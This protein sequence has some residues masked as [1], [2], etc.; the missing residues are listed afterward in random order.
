MYSTLLPVFCLIHRD[1][2]S[3]HLMNK[4]NHP[5]TFQ[6]KMGVASSADDENVTIVLIRTDDGGVKS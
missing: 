3:A 5:S 4:K 1:N 2:L 6:K